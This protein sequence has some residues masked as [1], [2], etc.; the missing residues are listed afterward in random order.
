M[1][2]KSNS[3]QKGVTQ[4]FGC[5]FTVVESGLD[6]EQVSEYI[7][8]LKTERDKL[9]AESN[10]YKK[11]EDHYESLQRLAKKTVMEADT[12]AEEIRSEMIA[13]TEVETSQMVEGV[14]DLII[15]VYDGISKL[16]DDMKEKI[17]DNRQKVERGMLP[18]SGDSAIKP[19][20]TIV[21][22]A[23]IPEATPSEHTD[24][25]KHLVAT[26]HDREIQLDIAPPIDVE[27]VSKIFSKLYD[28]PQVE[29]VE[30]V[31]SETDK[32]SIVILQKESVDPDKFSKTLAE[33]SEIKEAR[34]VEMEAAASSGGIDI[35]QR[36]KRIELTLAES[37]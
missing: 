9:W 20:S 22:A 25:N 18:L 28:L 6:A 7:Q 35:N 21:K 10:E 3:K 12:L 26:L 31:S 27:K 19:D 37:K 5:D 13:K 14:K 4:L 1:S 8:K 34:V 30:L 17:A 29:D 15:G 2:S 36:P 11:H 33:F 16:L 32:P 24:K 23:D